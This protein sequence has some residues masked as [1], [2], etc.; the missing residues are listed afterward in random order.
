MLLYKRGWSLLRGSGAVPHFI[1]FSIS[2]FRLIQEEGA[3]VCRQKQAGAAASIHLHC[4][5]NAHRQMESI[6]LNNPGSQIT[7]H[8]RVFPPCT[9]SDILCLQTHYLGEKKKT[10]MK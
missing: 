2:L 1:S 6:L 9:E 5:S 10:T 4:V 8:R 3:C 7:V